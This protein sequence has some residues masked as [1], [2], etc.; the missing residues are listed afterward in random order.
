THTPTIGVKLSTAPTSYS[1]WVVGAVSLHQPVNTA[2]VG[3]VVDVGLDMGVRYFGRQS[4]IALL[5]GVSNRGV[6]AVHP[7][8]VFLI[9]ERDEP[10]AQRALVQHLHDI[11]E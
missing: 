7:F 8:E 1:S 6:F 11:G 4:G 2:L 5:D 9:V 10:H 3:D